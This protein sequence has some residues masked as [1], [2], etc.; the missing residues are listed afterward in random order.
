MKPF[1]IG[2]DPG[3]SNGFAAYDRDAGRLATVETIK[4]IFGLI[5]KVK[6]FAPSDA[7]VILES[8]LNMGT[9]RSH[10][11]GAAQDRMSRNVGAV[12][13][14]TAEILQALRSLRYNVK[15]VLPIRGKKMSEEGFKALTGWEGK[16]SQHARDAG[17]L[18]WRSLWELDH[19]A[20]SVAE[21]RVPDLIRF[22]SGFAP[23]AISRPDLAGADARPV[24]LSQMHERAK[25]AIEV[26]A[27]RATR[28]QSPIVVIRSV[29]GDYL[30]GF[31]VRVTPEGYQSI[32]LE[33]LRAESECNA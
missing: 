21:I 9:F 7:D 14:V 29:S 3:K 6:T 16:T 2:I 27:K 4:G 13:A 18:C 23:F 25:A 12:Q 10:E 5:E 22:G 1:A 20:Y 30:D 26:A 15:T 11:S 31:A 19:R 17:R 28:Y 32:T 8:T 33:A 24:N